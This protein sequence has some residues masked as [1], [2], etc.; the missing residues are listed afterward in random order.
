M[1]KGQDRLAMPT[2]PPRPALTLAEL[3]RMALENNPTLPQ[4]LSGIEA[5]RGRATQAGLLPNPTV[6]YTG[7]EISGGPI[8]RGGE[9]GLFVEQTIPLGGKL[10]LS[11]QIFN[12]EAT[13]RLP[14]WR[15]S[16]F[17][18]GCSKAASIL[19]RGRARRR[20]A[21]ERRCRGAAWAPSG[22][23]DNNGMR[24]QRW[25]ST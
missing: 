13:A 10:G 12:R 25:L 22:R 7:S 14:G 9:H 21:R 4:A 5:A 23:G 20:P 2:A 19:R 1:V 16:S 18:A 6:G 17:R 3:E 11:R 8:I 15:R 24:T